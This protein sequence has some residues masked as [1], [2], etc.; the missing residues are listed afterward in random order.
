MRGRQVELCFSV[1]GGKRKGAGRRSRDGRRRVAHR[2]RP[3][4]SRHHPV[5]VT[6]RLREGLPNLRRR[7]C[8][9]LVYRVFCFA[10]R[11][12]GFRICHYS[13]QG[14]HLHLI[15]EAAD[16][17]ALSKGMQ[18]FGIRLARAVNKRCGR[19]GAV[20]SGRYDAR[21]ITTPRQMRNVLCYVLNN[22][23]RHNEDFGPDGVRGS[24]D[25]CSSALYFDGWDRAPGVGPPGAALPVAPAQT[26]L[27][28]VGWRRY[29][30]IGVE[31]V[32]A[33]GREGRGPRVLR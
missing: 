31:E 19:Q 23:R 2:R 16:E 29:G 5:H 32:P 25:P 12:D 27:L 33:A 30:A 18:G 4:L 8:Y 14:N 6:L 9:R 10:C 3:R 15:C 28:G 21:A 22:D 13:V 1:R 7:D 17:R 24:A 26:W 11:R 20:F